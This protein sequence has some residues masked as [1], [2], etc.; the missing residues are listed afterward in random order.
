MRKQ[1]EVSNFQG[2]EF[3]ME[4]DDIGK[5]EKQNRGLAINVFGEERE[6]IYP[7]RWSKIK[8][9]PINLLLISDSETR[10]YCLIKNMSRLLSSQVSKKEHKKAFLFEMLEPFHIERI[11]D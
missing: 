9:K 1:S 11:L 5:F 3:P 10:H 8:T 2:I 4:L 7:L 6:E